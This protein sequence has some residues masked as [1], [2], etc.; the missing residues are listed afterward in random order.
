MA[1]IMEDANDE[2]DETPKEQKEIKNTRANKRKQML[3]KNN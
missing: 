1:P 2:A 3:E